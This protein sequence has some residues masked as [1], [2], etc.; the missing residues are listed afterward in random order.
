MKRERRGNKV[1]YLF[2]HLVKDHPNH[3]TTTRAHSNLFPIAQIRERDL[4]FIATGTGI[5]VTLK[6]RVVSHVFDFDFI[7][8]V[9]RGHALS[10]SLCS[11]LYDVYVQ[12]RDVPLM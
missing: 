11:R 4:E 8:D 5:V 9:F 12:G 6:C 2:P 3:Q 10:G 7:V 1:S